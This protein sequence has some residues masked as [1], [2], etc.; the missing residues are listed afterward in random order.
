[1]VQKPPPSATGPSTNNLIACSSEGRAAVLR[2]L[3]ERGRA[4][5]GPGSSRGAYA[6]PRPAIGKLSPPPHSP[7]ERLLVE[8]ALVM[9]HPFAGAVGEDEFKTDAARAVAG[10]ARTAAGDCPWQWYWTATPSRPASAV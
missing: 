5:A 1:M 3:A 10:R 2:G 9:A 6:A 7:L 8:P 4:A